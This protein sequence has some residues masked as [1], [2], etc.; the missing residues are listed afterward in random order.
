MTISTA[1][2]TNFN[3]TAIAQPISFDNIFSEERFDNHPRYQ[4]TQTYPVQQA[5]VPDLEDLEYIFN[6]EEE[7]QNQAPEIMLQSNQI[8]IIPLKDTSKTINKKGIKVK[9]ILKKDDEMVFTVADVKNYLN[10]RRS[11]AKTGIREDHE[12]YIS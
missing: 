2:R 9:S 6:P 7:Q 5:P 10:E 1:S 12:T 3:P 4:K 8:D 11:K